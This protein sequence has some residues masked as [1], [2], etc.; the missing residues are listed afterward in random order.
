MK[1]R[2][3]ENVIGIIVVSVSVAFSLVFVIGAGRFALENRLQEIRIIPGRASTLFA[4]DSQEAI[5]RGCG[6]FYI[7]NTSLRR[8]IEVSD[9]DET[10]KETI[11]VLQRA[12]IE[13]RLITPDTTEA[14]TFSNVGLRVRVAEPGDAFWQSGS[15]ICNWRAKNPDGSKEFVKYP[16]YLKSPS[17][18]EGL[19]VIRMREFREL[20]QRATPLKGTLF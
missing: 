7:S 15:L 14:E 5:R 18:S 3:S 20:W 4:E 13:V 1:I 19:A 12:N 6:W 8:M 16:R 10:F 9:I 17:C 11:E 2:M